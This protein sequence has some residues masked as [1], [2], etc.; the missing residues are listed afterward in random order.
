MYSLGHGGVK[1]SK[2]W[3]RLNHNSICRSRWSDITN[4]L[5]YETKTDYRENRLGCHVEEGIY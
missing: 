4:E 2:N 1:D 3:A 5:I